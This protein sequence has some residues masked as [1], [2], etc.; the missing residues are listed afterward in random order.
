MWQ[1]KGAL[2]QLSL[3]AT[4]I[5]PL[6][7]AVILMLTVTALLPLIK[8]YLKD[9]TLNFTLTSWAIS[10]NCHLWS[11]TDWHL[12]MFSPFHLN[13]LADLKKQKK[14]QDKIQV[15][16]KSPGLEQDMIYRHKLG[17]SDYISTHI[18]QHWWLG[19]PA[20]PCISWHWTHSPLQL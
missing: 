3:D 8:T 1:M 4:E 10:I 13:L 16:I 11:L 5:R 14:T 2:S 19:Q 7:L 15:S 18:T 9:L 20:N 6:L 12:P 17:K